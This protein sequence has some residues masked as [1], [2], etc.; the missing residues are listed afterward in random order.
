MFFFCLIFAIWVQVPNSWDSQWRTA[1]YFIFVFL[2][3]F[4]I[5]VV[6]IP[7]SALAPDMTSD[8]DLRMKLSSSRSVFSFLVR[9]RAVQTLDLTCVMTTNQIPHVLELTLFDHP[10]ACS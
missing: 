4:A 3:N 2:Y 5:T 10:R 7:H 1:Y 8:Y 6:N 9:T